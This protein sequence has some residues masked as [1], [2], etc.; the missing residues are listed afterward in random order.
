MPENGAEKETRVVGFFCENSACRA[1][2]LA[3]D[4]P[5]ALRVIR[6]PCAGKVDELYILQALENGADGVLVLGCFTESCRSLRGNVRIK[7]RLVRVQEM[8]SEI[9][10]E[11][12][13]IKYCEVTGNQDRRLTA[14]IQDFITELTALP[15][16]PDSIEKAVKS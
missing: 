10:I 3:G 1:S 2:D 7:K 15:D 11:P 13:R 5:G 14:I 6:V 9:G 4:L 12:A 8:L 16:Q